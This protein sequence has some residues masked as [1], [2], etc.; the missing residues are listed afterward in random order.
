VCIH[1]PLQPFDPRNFDPGALADA[2]PWSFDEV[3]LGG[4]LALSGPRSPAPP[5]LPD[6]L[7]P[8]AE[9]VIDLDDLVGF[10]E[11]PVRA[12]LRRRLGIS[13]ASEEDEID[14]ALPIELDPLTTWGVAERLLEAL[15]RGSSLRVAA[16][17]EKARGT[18]PPD[19][20]GDRVIDT[21]R[22]A[23]IAIATQA[24]KI[25]AGHPD[26]DPIDVQ[27]P[28]DSHRLLSG[29]ISG[30]RSTMLMRTSYSRVSPRHRMA[31]WIRLLALSAA[32]PDEPFA[33]ATIGRATR[34]SDVRTCWIP[35]LAEDPGERRRIALAEL[36]PIVDLYDRG[37]R[38]PLPLSCDAS[39]AY[40]Q[41]GLVAAEKAW[42]SSFDYPKED[43]RPEHVLVYGDAIPFSE[44]LASTPGAGENW[45]PD[46]PSRFGA[47][48]RRLWDGLLARETIDDR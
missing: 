48:A 45:Y 3:A 25:R 4:A 17:A 39:A 8:L 23:V 19:S 36:A 26:R 44:L 9:P 46:E 27:V 32:H 10:A 29:T 28:L 35:P 21:V 40:L 47:Y 31:A 20:L 42:T 6:A 1:H 2:T 13:V 33:A 14:D 24:E 12:F 38:E 16:R 5:F 7:A 22:D 37:M 11:R 15:L 30:V 34:G 41:N 18:L 43:R